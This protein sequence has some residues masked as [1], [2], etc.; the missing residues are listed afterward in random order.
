MTLVQALE[1][2]VSS[3]LIS[4]DNQRC[5]GGIVE[6]NRVRLFGL[7]KSR[8]RPSVVKRQFTPVPVSFR[9]CSHAVTSHVR[10]FDPGG[11][12]FQ[13][14]TRFGNGTSRCSTATNS[15]LQQE[16]LCFIEADGVKP[17]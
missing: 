14:H 2:S 11:V 4:I 16:I 1:V 8:P 12:G 7:Y 17:R 3:W 6:H 5:V 15:G 9:S 13:E 10:V